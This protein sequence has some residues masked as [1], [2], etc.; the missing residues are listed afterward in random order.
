MPQHEFKAH[1]YVGLGIIVLAELL[2]IAGE[3]FVSHWLTPIAWTGYL[4]LT[5]ALIYRCKGRSL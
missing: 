4:L 5:D 1:G 3:P 2:L